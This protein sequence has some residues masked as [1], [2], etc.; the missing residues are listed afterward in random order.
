MA[1]ARMSLW[2]VNRI[3]PKG[4]E[5]R[6]EDSAHEIRTMVRKNRMRKAPMFAD[7]LTQECQIGLVARL[8]VGHYACERLASPVVHEDRQPWL[9][10]SAGIIL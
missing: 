1:N 9:G 4:C 7:A 2:P 3:Y 6:N 10:L 5:R 8:L